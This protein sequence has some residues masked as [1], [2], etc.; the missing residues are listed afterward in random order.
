[1]LI[2]LAKDGYFIFGMDQAKGMLNLAQTKIQK[3][4]LETQQRI[5]LQHIDVTSENWQ[6]GYDLVILGTIAFMN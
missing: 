2:P 5:L 1:M 3:L 6:T 4:P